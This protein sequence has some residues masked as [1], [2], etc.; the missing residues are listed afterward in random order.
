MGTRLDDAANRAFR[1]VEAFGRRQDAT[2]I[3]TPQ[4]LDAIW[5]GLRS[6]FPEQALEAARQA[7]V[8]LPA[9]DSRRTA[10]MRLREDIEKVLVEARVEADPEVQR[11]RSQ[12][13]YQYGWPDGPELD[14]EVERI[15]GSRKRSATQ[16]ALD[17][18]DR[19]VDDA[20]RQAE[21]Y[22]READRRR[23]EQEQWRYESPR[24]SRRRPPR[25]WNDDSRQYD[26]R[27]YDYR[28]YDSRQSPRR[29]P[30][31]GYSYDP[32]YGVSPGR[33]LSSEELAAGAAG[34]LIGVGVGY[35]LGKK[36]H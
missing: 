23:R 32:R 6:G 8:Q 4:Q 17:R 24:R 12:L 28:H 9:G 25:S 3:M 29:A 36:K 16:Q 11:V 22:Q 34:A 1:S 26:S 27:Q 15:V 2:D 30:S 18:Q 20:H 35:Y 19:P 14:R 5:Q 10:A 21:R 31:P 33:G 13:M 7:V